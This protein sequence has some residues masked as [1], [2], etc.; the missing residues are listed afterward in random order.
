MLLGPIPADWDFA[1]GKRPQSGLMVLGVDSMSPAG[2][3]GIQ[4]GAVITSIAG[5]PV[6]DVVELQRII[7][8]VPP[9]QWSIELHGVGAPAAAMASSSDR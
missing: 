5:R 9:D 1:G 7:N 2:K 8:D 3:E 6:A 4:S